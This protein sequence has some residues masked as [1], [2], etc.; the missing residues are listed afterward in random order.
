MPSGIKEF[1]SNHQRKQNFEIGNEFC[2]EVNIKSDLMCYRFST[3]FTTKEL[4]EYYDASELEN[5][6]HLLDELNGFDHPKT[7]IILDESPDEIVSGIWGLLPSWAKPD[8]YKKANTL[9]AQIENISVRNSYKD[10]ADN[11]CLIPAHLFYEWQHLD[12]KGKN[13]KKFQIGLRDHNIWSFAGIYSI[14]THE[15]T[16]NRY[17]T[18][19]IVTTEAN[20]IMSTIHNTKKRMPV[21]LDRNMDRKWLRGVPMEEFSFPKYDP[22]LVAEEA[23]GGIVDLFSPAKNT[24]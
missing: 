19:S 6:Y 9:N 18:Y 5:E 22:D 20:T 17:I 16:G 1:Q 14:W 21:C 24:D 15:K 4:E 13:K 3:K 23:S 8:F 7:A 10:S 2:G 12:N 11:R